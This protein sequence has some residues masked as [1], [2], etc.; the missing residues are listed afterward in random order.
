MPKPP[1]TSGVTTRNFSGGSLKM[2]VGQ[3]ALRTSQ[4]PW[5]L[6][7]SVKWPRAGVVLGERGARLHG[8]DDDAVVHHRQPRDM[9]GALSISA[10]ALAASPTSQS[11]QMLLGAL[12]PDLRLAGRR[13]AVAR[14]VA[15]GRMS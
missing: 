9:R 7:C 2:F 6:V 10:S 14:S 1:P 4:E 3:Q 15:A 13:C 12:V 11:K 8:G 5:V